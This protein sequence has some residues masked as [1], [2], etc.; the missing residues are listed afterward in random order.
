M[1]R[2][3]HVQLKDV[4]DVRIVPSPTVIK[5]EAVARYVEVGAI[6]DGTQRRGCRRRYRKS[7]QGN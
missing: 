7:A 6:V 4:A 2:G 1:R 5:R 3:G